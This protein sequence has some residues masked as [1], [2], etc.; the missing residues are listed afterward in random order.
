MDT[1][2][3]GREAVDKV[4]DHSGVK[5]MKWGVRKDRGHEGERAKTRKINRLDKKYDKSFKGV[6]GY[7]KINNAIAYKINPRIDIMNA[8]SEYKDVNLYENPKLHKKYIKEYEKNLKEVVN[9]VN[10]DFGTNASGTRRMGLKVVGKGDDMTWEAQWED[11]SHASEDAIFCV[12]PT[13]TSSGLITGQKIVGPNDVLTHG[14]EFVLEHFGV[15]G[16]HWGVR[17]S[18]AERR[19]AN[20]SEDAKRAAANKAVVKEHGVS[21]LDNKELQHLVDRMNLEQRYSKLKGDPVSVKATKKGGKFVGDIIGNV[22]KTQA[23]KVANDQAA[24]QVAKLL[25]KHARG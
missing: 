19:A 16:M 8:K 12:I 18:R 17:R 15:K 6:H 3:R 2:T 14:E 20:A 22:V 23:T 5:G 11:V 25:A 4:L 1:L 7:I 21:A 9:E 10:A 13:R 24:K